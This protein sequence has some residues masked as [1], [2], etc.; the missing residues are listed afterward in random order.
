[1]TYASEVLADSP[2]VYL[3]LGDT[4]GTTAVDSSGNGRNGTYLNS[5][6]LN[7]SG[8]PG[9]AD[10]AVLLDGTN[11]N[12]SVP[13]NSIYWPSA[14][15]SVTIECWY[16][17]TDV[18][19]TLA[20]GT[21]GPKAFVAANVG[22]SDKRY[23]LGLDGAGKVRCYTDAQYIVT[24]PSTTTVNDNNWHHIVLTIT[25]SSYDTELYV[26]GTLQ[27]TN[28]TPNDAGQGS[29]NLVIGR[30][31]RQATNGYLA[32]RVDEVAVY[33]TKLSGARILAHYQA[34]INGI[35]SASSSLTVSGSASG[36]APSVGSASG[37]LTL[38]GAASGEPVSVVGS[39]SGALTITGSALGTV[40]IYGTA[41][42]TLTITGAASGFGPL[43]GSASGTLTLGGSAFGQGPAAPAPPHGLLAGFC[44]S[45]VEGDLILNGVPMKTPAWTCSNLTPLWEPAGI[46]GTDR[47]VPEASGVLARRRRPTM[48][49]YSIELSVG[50]F[51]DMTGLAAPGMGN[52]PEEFEQLEY[53]LDFLR[54]NVL[55]PRTDPNPDGT[56]LG[57]LIMPS[58]EIRTAYLH[59]LGFTVNV[60]VSHVIHGVLDLSVPSGGFV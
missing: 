12:V 35:G 29:P 47:I 38:T 18:G 26:D 32:G 55:D 3:K 34:G 2:L 41:V 48:S 20:A 31:E 33:G 44:R 49:V 50:G 28:S 56:I 39:A 58:G 19:T 37:P 57:E 23:V 8:I 22:G 4:S 40:S 1:M 17:G 9:S 7:Q 5:P 46:R 10:G 24:G 42:G 30:N 25:A 53:N 36:F 52:G 60:R 45:T 21:V 59:V 54:Q 43:V 13:T 15:V 27:A 51:A 11:D 16:K 14:T 6:T